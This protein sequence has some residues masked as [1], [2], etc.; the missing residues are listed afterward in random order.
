[1]NLILWKL[2]VRWFH[3]QWIKC[4]HLPMATIYSC[5][6][7]KIFV[8]IKKRGFCLFLYI[9]NHQPCSLGWMEMEICWTQID[10]K[11]REWRECW[12]NRKI[13]RVIRCFKKISDILQL[14]FSKESANTF[15]AGPFLWPTLLRVMPDLLLNV[16]GCKMC[17]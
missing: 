13:T 6:V 9:H 1:M 16:L 5:G 2:Y 12:G 17:L 15:Y 11:R 8:E 4:T 14:G 7:W 10:E 3:F